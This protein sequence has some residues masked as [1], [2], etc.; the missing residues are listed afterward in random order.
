[1]LAGYG[2]VGMGH[3]GFLG[4]WGGERERGE[5]DLKSSSSLPLHV[6]ERRRT[7][8]FKTTQCSG[9]FLRKE[10]VIWKNPKIGYDSFHPHD[11]VSIPGQCM[12]K[13][14]NNLNPR[15]VTGNIRAVSRGHLTQT[16]PHNIHI[17]KLIHIKFMQ[18]FIIFQIF[19]KI[20]KTIYN[21]KYLLH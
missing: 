21:S 18:Q 7:V 14:Y 19:L 8:S 17:I 20:N 2:C 10:N 15:S 12:L 11:V 1:V 6:Q 16:K 4:K 3:A 5:N 13:K 9:F